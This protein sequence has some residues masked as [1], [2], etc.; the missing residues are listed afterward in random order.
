MM[1]DDWS[2]GC[3][4]IGRS[5]GW[6]VGWAVGLRGGLVGRSSQDT[7]CWIIMMHPGLQ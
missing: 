5:V 7:R 1:I 4:L 2:A 6:S 3:G